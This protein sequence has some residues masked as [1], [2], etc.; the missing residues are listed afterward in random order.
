MNEIPEKLKENIP[1]NKRNATIVNEMLTVLE[2][3]KL[4]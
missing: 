3:I 1:N 2:Q 4:M